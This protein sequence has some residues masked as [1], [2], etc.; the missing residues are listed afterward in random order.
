[1]RIARIAMDAGV[2][3]ALVHYHFDTREALLD[4][5]LEYSFE[6]PA[7]CASGRATARPAPTPAARARWSTNASR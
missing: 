5:A 3:T 4:E 2:S 7:T 6:Q 1:M